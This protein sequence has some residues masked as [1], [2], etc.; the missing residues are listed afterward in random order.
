MILP[1]DDKVKKK[2]ISEILGMAID[3]WRGNIMPEI[4]ARI[5]I[6]I[7]EMLWLADLE[8]AGGQFTPCG[9]Q[10]TRDKIDRV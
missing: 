2:F 4:D 3:R 10:E 1:F 9:W 8:R 5:E 6:D 7:A